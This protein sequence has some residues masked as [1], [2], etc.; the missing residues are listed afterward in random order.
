MSDRMHEITT[1]TTILGLAVTLAGALSG[2]TTPSWQTRMV[3][4]DGV[5]SCR[6]EHGTRFGRSLTRSVENKDLA[7]FLFVERREGVVRIGVDSE[8][9]QPINGMAH[10]T[11]DNGLPVTVSSGAIGPVKSAYS[12]VTGYHAQSIVQ[13][14]SRARRVVLKV[15]GA[16]GAYLGG[17]EIKP[18]SNFISALLKCGVPL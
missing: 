12:A 3:E 16:D 9:P 10:L 4:T 1:K 6:V 15:E 5:E 13:R 18:D 7:Y 14:M 17:G 2:C 8:P 11:V